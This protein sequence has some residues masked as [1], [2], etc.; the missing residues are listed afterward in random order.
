MEFPIRLSGGFLEIF[1][2]G[3][4]ELTTETCDA[5]KSQ[6]SASIVMETD[7]RVVTKK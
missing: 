5:G 1:Q 6:V 3:L 4:M 7:V 2:T